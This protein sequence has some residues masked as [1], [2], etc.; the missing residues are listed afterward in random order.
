MIQSTTK[1]SESVFVFIFIVFFLLLTKGLKFAGWGLVPILSNLRYFVIICLPVYTL[2][3][4]KNCQKKA[5]YNKNVI[6]Y[7]IYTCVTTFFLRNLFYG[8]GLGYGL[9]CNLFVAAIFCS[10][11]VFHYKN[12]NDSISPFSR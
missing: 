12:R 7:F 6:L 3:K 11:F 10:Y 9:E 8:G 5:I 2:L 1:K 4:I